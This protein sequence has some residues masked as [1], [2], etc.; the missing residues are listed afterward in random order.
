MQWLKK[1]AIARHTTIRK[2]GCS[3][4]E[5]RDKKKKKKKNAGRAKGRSKEIKQ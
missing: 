5:R 4:R 3:S 1:E 2:N